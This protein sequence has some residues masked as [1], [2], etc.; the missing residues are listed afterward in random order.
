[1]RGWILFI[2]KR[3]WEGEGGKP[4]GTSGKVFHVLIFGV[5]FLITVSQ[6]HKLEI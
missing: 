1:M 6:K 5:S 4:G 3:E 2:S